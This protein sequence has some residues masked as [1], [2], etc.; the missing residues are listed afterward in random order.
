MPTQKQRNFDKASIVKSRELQEL[1]DTLNNTTVGNL[2]SQID[3]INRKIDAIAGLFSI[4]FNTNGTLSSEAYT[5]H[6]HNY[7]DETIADTADGTGT[8]TT[9]TK[10]TTGVV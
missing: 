3:L 4:L 7:E 5:T 6:T 2:Q 1:I 8:S 10:T 9:T